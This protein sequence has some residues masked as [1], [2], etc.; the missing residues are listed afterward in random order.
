VKADSANLTGFKAWRPDYFA[1]IPDADNY[2]AR[3][4]LLQIGVWLAVALIALGL[5]RLR[6]GL[7]TQQ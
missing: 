6:E 7:S 3:S 2:F 4:A 1:Y 5:T